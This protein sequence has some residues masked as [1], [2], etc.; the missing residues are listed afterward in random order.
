MQEVSKLEKDCITVSPDVRTINI[1]WK[2][3]PDAGNGLFEEL[4]TAYRSC[5]SFEGVDDRGYQIV[6]EHQPFLLDSET[7]EQNGYFEF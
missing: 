2:D 3:K 1:T 4:L 5:N 7:E 6:K